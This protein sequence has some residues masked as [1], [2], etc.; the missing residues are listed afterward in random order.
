MGRGILMSGEVLLKALRGGHAQFDRI[1]KLD[2]PLGEDWLVPLYVKLHARLGRNFEVIVD[3]SS[4]M[5]DKIKLSALIL[6]P[7]TLWI[8]QTDGGYYR[9]NH[10]LYYMGKRIGDAPVNGEIRIYVEDRSN[11][12]PRDWP[13]NSMWC[14]VAAHADILETSDGLRV[15]RVVYDN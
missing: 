8:R 12:K 6:K 14:Q 7:V 10:G 11:P 9:V 3:A 1:I 2:T 13:A 15:E 5:G 4:V